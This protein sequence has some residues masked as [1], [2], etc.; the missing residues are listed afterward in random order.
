MEVDDKKDARDEKSQ[1]RHRLQTA[2]Q[3]LS[4]TDR[5]SASQRICEHIR[6]LEVYQRAR[7]VGIYAATETE[8]SLD[9][10]IP[11]SPGAQQTLCFPRVSANAPRRLE[12]ATITAASD[13]CIGSYGIREPAATIPPIDVNRID[14]L[15][16]PGVG[17]DRQGHRLG[18]G[19]GYYD[20]LLAQYQGY[21][22]GVAFACQL[23]PQLPTDVHDQG[24]HCVVTETEVLTM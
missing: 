22:I 8:A 9:A 5:Q 21:R 7:C 15:C 17:F 3:A 13:L 19:A 1:L 11:L 18:R 20:R 16:I 24:V 10:L 6:H 12:W 14:C 4:V 23:V 2:R